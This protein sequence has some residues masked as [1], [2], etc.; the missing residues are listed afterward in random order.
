[1]RALLVSALDNARRSGDPRLTQRIQVFY[2]DLVWRQNDRSPIDDAEFLERCDE[3][4]DLCRD[5]LG[6]DRDQAA[7][8]MERM[9]RRIESRLKAIEGGASPEIRDEV[10]RR[11]LTAEALA[12]QLLF[13][14]RR[15][16]ESAELIRHVISSVRT[17]Q[18]DAPD[19]DS[20]RLL[21]ME[22]L[23][24]QS[25][26]EMISGEVTAA[27][28]SAADAAAI[29]EGSNSLLARKVTST[30]GSML[31]SEDPKGGEKI[32]RDC[33]GSWADDGTSDAA[34][35]HVHLSMAL[36]LQAHRL[37]PGD[38]ARGALLGEAQDRMTRVHDSCRRLGMYVDAG[39]AALVRGVSSGVSGDGDEVTWFAQG[40]AAAARGRQMET[41]WRSHINLAM[42]LC[43]KEGEP[44]MTACNHAVA[45]YEIMQETLAV[46]SEPERSPRFE[47]LRVGLAATAWMLIASGDEKGR[48]ILERY[49]KLRLHFS[50]PEAG[51]LAP[52]DG[53][54]R[55]YQW[56]RVDDVDYVLY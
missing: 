25:C 3:E 17:Q 34:L 16:T 55:H 41:L 33:L 15:P 43:R 52:Y 9:S 37:T 42:S 38:E 35:V 44:S 47:M 19:R 23:Y 21:E 56:L 2:L 10:L 6:V 54:P 46:Y 32:L 27:V 40:V 22:A 51:V 18:L 26:A 12:A 13:N 39:A 24:T 36:V 20:W 45:A 53:S 1:A 5:F 8:R 29:A 31:L 7:T 11:H 14:D 28:R 4:L 49:P 30:Y 50:D 48:A